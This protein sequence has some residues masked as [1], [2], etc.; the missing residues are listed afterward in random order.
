MREK[1]TFLTSKTLL[2]LGFAQRFSKPLFP[3]GDVV[4]VAFLHIRLFDDI[5]GGIT[6]EERLKLKEGNPSLS[7]GSLKAFFDPFM[8]EEKKSLLLI[9]TQE[10]N[11]TK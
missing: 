7:Y 5:L 1:K 10:R 8:Y 3:K 9:E 11:R 6:K 2:S 4:G